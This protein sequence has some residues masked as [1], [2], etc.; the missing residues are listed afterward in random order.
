MWVPCILGFDQE[1]GDFN[2]F[3][4][5]VLHFGLFYVY[6][7][8]V[9]AADDEGGLVLIKWRLVSLHFLHQVRG[10]L[11][12]CSLLTRRDARVMQTKVSIRPPLLFFLVIIVV[13]A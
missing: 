8:F 2:M 13:V 1:L 5:P 10:A 7:C 6:G 9:A 12:D 4:E 3:D 11:D